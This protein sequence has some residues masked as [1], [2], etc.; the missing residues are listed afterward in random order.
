[1]RIC[2]NIYEDLVKEDEDIKAKYDSKAFTEFQ[3]VQLYWQLWIQVPEDW[4][5][6]WKQLIQNLQFNGLIEPIDPE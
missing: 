2:V 4:E 3:V 6:E 1:M 5:S